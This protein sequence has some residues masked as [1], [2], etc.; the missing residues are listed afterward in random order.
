MSQDAD[1]RLIFNL[2]PTRFGGGRVFEEANWKMAYLKLHVQL[3]DTYK[4]AAN[5]DFYDKPVII[6]IIHISKPNIIVTHLNSTLENNKITNY[7]IVTTITK[8][9][10][11]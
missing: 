1:G 2:I 9:I 11:L 7:Y 10:S 4:F 6:K 8:G 3:A 5:L